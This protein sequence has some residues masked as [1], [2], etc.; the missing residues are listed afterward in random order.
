[1]HILKS[2]GTRNDDYSGGETEFDQN[3][4]LSFVFRK[5][6]VW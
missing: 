5:C 4:M 6:C 1:M 2:K 3:F